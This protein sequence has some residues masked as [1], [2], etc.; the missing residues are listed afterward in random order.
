MALQA[1]LTSTMT[2]LSEKHAKISGDVCIS[3]SDV[4]LGEEF[5]QSRE[6]GFVARLLLDLVIPGMSGLEVKQQPGGW[7]AR[8]ANPASWWPVRSRCSQK[9]WTGR[10]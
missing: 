3:G 1:S 10:Y 6:L 4:A 2:T 9:L 8:Y 7:R 5:F